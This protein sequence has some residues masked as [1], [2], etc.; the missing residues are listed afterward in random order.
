MKERFSATLIIP[1]KNR[2]ADLQRAVR[3]VLDQTAGPHSL[4]IVNYRAPIEESRIRVG[5][6]IASASV[7][8]DVGWRLSY[9]QDAKISGGAMARNRAM[10]IADG[11]IWLFLDDDVVLEPDFVEQ[12]L[13]VYR[14]Y[15]QVDGVSGIIT[16]YSRPGF[17]FRIWTVIF[18]RGPFRDE[19][20]PIYWNA[21]SLRGSGPIAVFR[22]T[23]ALMASR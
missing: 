5:A 10:E 6:E 9:I 3:S 22:F 21:D 7:R 11:D 1:T 14:E 18:V 15:P 16:N 20:Q 4:I 8:A 2:P 19:R 23:G 13:A 17:L 12:L